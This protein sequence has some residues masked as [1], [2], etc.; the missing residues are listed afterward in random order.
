M[1]NDNM[2]EFFV[3]CW[4]DGS[5]PTVTQGRRYINHI[6][7]H[8]GRPPLN[9]HHRKNYA[10]VLDVLKGLEREVE[11]RDHQS[12]GAEPLPLDY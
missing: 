10:T 6:L 5:K 1:T 4:E 12:K 8:Y 2:E 7:T 3:Q 11:W 9:K